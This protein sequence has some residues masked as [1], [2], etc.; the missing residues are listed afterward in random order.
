MRGHI[1][2]LQK[3]FL[4]QVDQL[5]LMMPSLHG[6][7]QR[8]EAALYESIASTCHRSMEPYL[9]AV[10]E[11]LLLMG[12]QWAGGWGNLIPR[13]SVLAM[14]Q[15]FGAVLHLISIT[16]CSQQLCQVRIIAK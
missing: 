11:S 12:K 10:S 5:S 14:G 6:A 13:L 1:P 16:Y 2:A 3:A 9:Q 15:G 4:Q 8:R 7:L